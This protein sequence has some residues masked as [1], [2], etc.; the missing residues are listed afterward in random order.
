MNLH[1]MR[2]EYRL[3]ER[4][5]KNCI[6]EDQH[7]Q[8]YC[9]QDIPN[10]QS[11]RLGMTFPT[12]FDK[13]S[14]YK[15]KFYNEFWGKGHLD[16]KRN[17]DNMPQRGSAPVQVRIELKQQKRKDQKSSGCE[18]ETRHGLKRNLMYL[19]VLVPMLNVRTWKFRGQ[20]PQPFKNWLGWNLASILRGDERCQTVLTP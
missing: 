5:Q 6:L 12:L 20:S 4:I 11:P 18:K 16:Q 13:L 15:V 10:Q 14:S 8:F 1:Q 9:P 3:V 2:L 17:I 7:G 19:Y